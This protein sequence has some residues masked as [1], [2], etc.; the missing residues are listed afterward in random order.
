MIYFIKI[1]ISTQ[2]FVCLF[3]CLFVCFKTKLLQEHESRRNFCFVS[4]K[5][6]WR[7]SVKF[8]KSEVK[9][10]D[11]RTLAVS[12]ARHNK[13]WGDRGHGQAHCPT[14]R[15]VRRITASWILDRNNEPVLRPN[16]LITKIFFL[17]GLGIKPWQ[18]FFPS[19]LN[20]TTK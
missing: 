12:W 11:P 8:R 4:Y 14:D 19:H 10:F 18:I 1:K 15:I 17:G 16:P 7:C 3:V 9:R 5:F 13:C 6:E 2:Y 20:Y